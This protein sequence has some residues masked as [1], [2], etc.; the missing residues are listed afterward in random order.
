MFTTTLRTVGGS[1]MFAIPKPMLEGLGLHANQQVGVSIDHGRLIVEP[2]MRPRF[3]LADLLAECD[4]S[5][6]IT[7]EDREWLDS[8]PVGDE[9]I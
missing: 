7:D 3:A 6:P 2:K 9:V 8:P 4:F 5:Q 1:V